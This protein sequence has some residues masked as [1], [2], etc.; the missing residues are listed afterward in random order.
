MTEFIKI[1]ICDEGTLKEQIQ[2]HTLDK[3]LRKKL[4]RA[5][6]NEDEQ[7]VLP[8]ICEVHFRAYTI[9]YIDLK[10]DSKSGI[11]EPAG[12]PL[13]MTDAEFWTKA[14]RNLADLIEASYSSIDSKEE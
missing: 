11:L 14:S 10:D 3:F 1:P 5:S 6:K 2:K 7:L 12:R 8:G 13:D 9:I 4:I